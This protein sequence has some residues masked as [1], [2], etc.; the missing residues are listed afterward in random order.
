MNTLRFARTYEPNDRGEQKLSM[1]SCKANPEGAWTDAN[2]ILKKVVLT[3]P[4]NIPGIQTRV[5]VTLGSR[6]RTC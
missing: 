5:R 4:H 1:V 6:G 3:H 2:T